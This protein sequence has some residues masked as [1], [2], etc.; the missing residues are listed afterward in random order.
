[1]KCWKAR[2]GAVGGFEGG[3]EG[4]FGGDFTD[5]K[6]EKAMEEIA[7]YRSTLSAK[8]KQ[9][10][11]RGIAQALNQMGLGVK[12][13]ASMRDIAEAIKQKLPNPSVN[14]Q[15]FKSESNAQKELCEL[16]ANHLNNVFTPGAEGSNRLIDLREGPANVCRAVFE[17]TQALATGAQTEF[18]KI[19]AQVRK[20]L[21]NIEIFD[22]VMQKMY[23]KVIEKAKLS[24]DASL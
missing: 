13:D 2:K 8:F 10:V 17:L 7:Q 11:V 6:A 18:L 21:R 16:I 4:F 3:D 14:G 5:E 22:L 20:A 9:D 19:Q 1:M 23:G 24:A 15:A 12:T